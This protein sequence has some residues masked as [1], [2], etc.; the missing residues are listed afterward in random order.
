[1][2]SVPLNCRLRV[3]YNDVSGGRRA[4]ASTRLRSCGGPALPA[5]VVSWFT[6]FVVLPVPDLHAAMAPSDRTDVGPLRPGRS[7]PPSGSLGVV[8]SQG[9][10]A[11]YNELR[12]ECGLWGGALRKPPTRRT[13]RP[14][15]VLRASWWSTATGGAGMIV[16]RSPY[17]CKAKKGKFSPG[18]GRQGPGS[19][20]S[21]PS[22]RG[23]TRRPPRR[24]PAAA[25]G[26][27][28]GGGSDTILT[29]EWFRTDAAVPQLRLSGLQDGVNCLRA[30]ALP[31]PPRCGTAGTDAA[32][33]NE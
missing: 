24:R 16:P 9:L 21:R 33:T 17:S 10:N 4:H 25:A 20:A 5:K 7:V 18:I 2:P 11:R 12:L 29:N 22:L 8:A 23:V 1:M 6:F 19:G 27:C 3:P 31:Q 26:D 28:G 14:P 15:C 13:V 30:D 32:L